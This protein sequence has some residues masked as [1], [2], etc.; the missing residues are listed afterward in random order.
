MP[1]ILSVQA[2][3]RHAGSH[4]RQLSNELIAALSGPGD[5]TVT[6][7][8]LTEPIPQVDENWLGANWTPTED[9]KAEQAQALQLSDALIAE[10]EAADIIVI[11]VPVYNFTI[12]AALKAWIDQ[13]ARAGRTF[14]YSESGPVGLLE[15]K[16]AYLVVASG[17]VPVDSPVDFATPYLRHVLGFVGITD[18]EVIAA[19]RLVQH[20]DQSL[21]QARS[22]ITQI[23]DAVAA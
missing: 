17:G 22:T 3:A 4:S 5:H 1:H 23:A 6:T 12:P 21:S 18:V 7:R 9:R 8:D 14:R 11:G 15:G 2:S 16:A 19:D 13:I 20:A 10:V